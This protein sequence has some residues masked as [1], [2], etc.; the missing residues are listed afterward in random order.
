M[1]YIGDFRLK[2]DLK[3]PLFDKEKINRKRG[4]RL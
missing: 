4:R 2:I 3:L 1:I